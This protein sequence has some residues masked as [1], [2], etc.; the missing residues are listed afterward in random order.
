LGTTDNQPLVIR[1]NN[2]ERVRVTETGTIGIGTVPSLGA[3]LESQTTNASGAVE[4]IFGKGSSGVTLLSGWPSIGFNAYYDYTGN[5]WRSLV[6]GWTGNISVDQT[7]GVMR[8]ELPNSSVSAGNQPVTHT[9]RMSITPTGRVGIGTLAP[10]Q[11]LH[12]EGSAYVSAQLGIG[13]SSP[14]H[15]LQ[16]SG[17]S[18]LL[19]SSGDFRLLLSKNATANAGSVI[20][21]TNFSGRAELGLLAGSD[22]FSLRVSPDGTN[23]TDAFAVDRTTAFVGIGTTSPSNRLHVI[24]TA[25]PLR[26]QGLQ[27]DNTLD[28]VLVVASTGVVKTRS[29]STL[30][31]ANAWSLT[32]NSGTNPSTNFLGTTDNQPLAL[33]TNNTERMRI[34]A[35]GNVGIG[36]TAPSNPLHVSASADPVRFEGVQ[37]EA[38]PT[39]VLTVTSTGVVKKASVSAIVGGTIIK[40]IFTPTTSGSQFTISPGQDIQ[41]G[42]VVVVTVYGPSGGGVV[43]SM[44]TN[45]NATADTFTVATTMTIDNTYAIHYIIINP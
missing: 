5:Q 44:V 10:A 4:A 35:S 1:T 40:G 8:F 24:A 17:S 28:Q 20:F 6:A 2:T 36:T 38:S 11:A 13:V 19:S 37:T 29:A 23:W 22:N 21:Q 27:N 15:A 34:D 32:G 31:A 41:T 7:S 39:Q 42:A 43:G 9:I 25:D 16:V 45:I 18:A 33:R 3:R 14:T 26:L 30:V 12:V